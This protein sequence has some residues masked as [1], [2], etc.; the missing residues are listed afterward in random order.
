MC[1]SSQGTGSASS[2]RSL[3]D[4]RSD[5]RRGFIL[6][7]LE[8]R[9]RFARVPVPRRDKSYPQ[10]DSISPAPLGDGPHSRPPGSDGRAHTSKG[11]RARYDQ[12]LH[13]QTV[14]I[15]NA[16]QVAGALRR[17]P[18]RARDPVDCLYGVRDSSPAESTIPFAL[19]APAE[20][21]CGYS[22]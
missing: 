7:I 5:I 17:A 3:S 22:S 16:Q 18:I 9:S 8:Q 6:E 21:V 10:G 11:P 12:L 20:C 14:F 4:S 15:Y 19:D 13:H 1:R 2:G